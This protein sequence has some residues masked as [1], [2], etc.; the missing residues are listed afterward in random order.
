MINF[1][2]RNLS[3][4]C[5]AL[6]V[7]IGCWIFVMNDQ[8]PQIEN[9]YTVPITVVNAPDGYQISKD[10]DDVKLRVKAQ[11]SLFAN[12][13]ASD[14]K[15]YVDLKDVESGTH[16]LQVQAVLPSGF[17]L[18]SVGPGKVTVNVDKIEEK[19][20][21][22]RLKL[23]GAAGGG[24]VVAKVE[25]SLQN[26]TVEGPDSVLNRVT[27]VI[28]YIG[29]N[30]SSDDFNVTVPLVAVDDREQKVEG[31]KLIPKTVD[32]NISLARGLN[33][34]I[35]DIKP[36]LM[37]DLPKDYILKSVKVEP[38]KIEISG[39]ADAI[40]PLMYLP[41]ESISLANMTKATTLTVKLS[42]PGG[43]TVTNTDVTVYIDVEKKSEPSTASD[44]NS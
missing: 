43:V 27:A 16:E 41:T 3:E 9:T 25:Q 32:V 24:K 39:D 34:K 12:V 15:V 20:V 6:I 18:V 33:T 19:E 36:T 35:I 14:F 13:D 1:F 31:V 2:R 40:G 26:V 22:I 4:K 28:G 42:V 21:P 29:L 44:K 10:V 7:A 37:S 11:R 30:G 8:N 5:L 38:E 23:S 17:D